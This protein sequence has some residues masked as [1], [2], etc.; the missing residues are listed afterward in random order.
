MSE[1]IRIRET[2][3]GWL[4]DVQVGVANVLGYPV[5]GP[6]HIFPR[7]RSRTRPLLLSRILNR[8]RSVLVV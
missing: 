2:T 7:L 5:S 1:E 4:G 3:M 8:C 6:L